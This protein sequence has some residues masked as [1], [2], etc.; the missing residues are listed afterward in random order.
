MQQFDPPTC[1]ISYLYCLDLE[2]AFAHVTR[3]WFCKARATVTNMAWSW[4][5]LCPCD[6]NV[7]VQSKIWQQW[8]T[9]LDR[10]SA[11]A[12]VTKMWLCKAELA[13]MTNTAYSGTHD[14]SHPQCQ[15]WSQR[16][17][18]CLHWGV[19][20]RG[21]LW[22][23]WSVVRDGLWWGWSIVRGGLWLGWSI[24]KGGLW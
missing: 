13:T 22:W 17:W 6:Q 3:M 16:G 12:H 18:G 24:V 11:F 23:G 8:Q 15:Q 5:C 4:Q 20:L 21:N 7:I 1:F 2:N 9:W 19:V 14:E 10:D